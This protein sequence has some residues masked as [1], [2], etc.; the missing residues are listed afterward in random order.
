MAAKI[1][2][3]ST[4]DNDSFECELTSAETRIG[5]SELTKSGFKNNIV[6]PDSQISREHALIIKR[7]DKY[8]LKDLDSANGTYLNAEKISNER[9]LKDKDSIQIGSF[10]LRVKLVEETVPD[11]TPPEFTPAGTVLLRAPSNASLLMSRTDLTKLTVDKTN[12]ESMKKELEELRKKAEILSHL[13]ELG[14]MFSSVFA[15]DEIFE[16]MAKMLFQLTPAERCLVQIKDTTTGELKTKFIKFRSEQHNNSEL[17]SPPRAIVEQALREQVTLLSLDAQ[18]DERIMGKS[19]ML[20]NVQSVICAP[21]I[22]NAKPLGVLYIDTHKSKLVFSP[23]DLDLMNAIAAQTS[24]ALDNAANHER[25]MKEALAREAY[26]RFLPDH[27]VNEILVSPD[28]LKLGGTNK[29]ATILFADVRGFTPLSEKLRPEEVVELLNQYFTIMTEKIFLHHG[30]LDKYIGDG[31][32]ALFGVAYA[33]EESP[34]NAVKAAI[35]M[36]KS[37]VD[38]REEFKQKYDAAVSIGIGINTGVITVGY[39]G[40]D[41]RMEYTGIGDPVNLASRL[42]S[43]TKPSQI[44]V[45]SYTHSLLKDAFPT[46]PLGKIAV[47][48]KSEPQEVYE[49]V[50]QDYI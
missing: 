10:L 37:M 36:Q 21:L 16:R 26:S 49:I 41:R 32:M 29:E 30:L 8:F 48:G 11:I 35:D 43:N 47:K 17:I 18:M 31:M 2:V 44:L 24:M 20:Q 1:L 15:F 39:I 27:I 33:A 40:S 7:G 9:L 13:Y 23:D 34:S 50:W 14:S 6:L 42:E 46:K 3:R 4:I 38:L 28:S 12:V 45:S 5:R 19:V 25:L 22:A